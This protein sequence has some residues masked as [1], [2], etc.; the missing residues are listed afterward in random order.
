LAAQLVLDGATTSEKTPVSLKNNNDKKKEVEELDTK[1]DVYINRD[2]YC[3]YCGTEVTTKKKRELGNRREVTPKEKRG[4]S[5]GGV[6]GGE[7]MEGGRAEKKKKNH[8]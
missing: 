5:D 2:G 4:G 6:K 1:N 3:N 7:A 8:S